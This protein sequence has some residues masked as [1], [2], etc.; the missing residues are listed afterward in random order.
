VTPAEHLAAAEQGLAGLTDVGAGRY[1]NGDDV[2]AIV[3]LAHAVI[4]LAAEQGIPHA[5]PSPVE[6]PSAGS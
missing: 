2:K 5:P 6:V 1:M 3:A 4:A